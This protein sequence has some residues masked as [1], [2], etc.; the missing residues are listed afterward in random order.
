MDPMPSP[1]VLTRMTTYLKKRT[2]IA[3]SVTFITALAAL[4]GGY[5]LFT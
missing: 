1:M 5:Y 3:S 2:A 4:F